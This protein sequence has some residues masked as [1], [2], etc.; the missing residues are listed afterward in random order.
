MG[1]YSTTMKSELELF[2]SI[3]DIVGMKFLID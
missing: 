1:A 3:I 2:I